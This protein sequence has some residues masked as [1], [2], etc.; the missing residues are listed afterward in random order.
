M[1]MKV[2][3]TYATLTL[4]YLEYKLHQKLI[5]LWGEEL[6]EKIKSKW[7]IFLADCF[8]LWDESY[9]KLEVLH[10]MLNEMNPNIKF[11]K[12]TSEMELPF[13]DVLVK[14]RNT[15]ITTDIY[16]KVTDTH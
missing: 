2:A 4:G 3:P 15:R 9:E 16:Y 1:G 14:K 12:D 11:T 7:K 8:I 10:K 6:A 13:L 5:T